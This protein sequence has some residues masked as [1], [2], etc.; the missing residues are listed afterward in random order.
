V[1]AGTLDVV[2]AGDGARQFAFKAATVA[3]R[4]HELAGAQALVLVEDFETDVAVAG[5]TPAAAS[6]RRARDRSSALTSKAPELG[7]TV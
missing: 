1:H 3:G 5:V 4:F 7:S 6:F 2:Q